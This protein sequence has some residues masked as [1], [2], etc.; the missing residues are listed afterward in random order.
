MIAKYLRNKTEFTKSKNSHS[1][2]ICC[3]CLLLSLFILGYGKD[4]YIKNDWNNF[5]E[6][7][8]LKDIVLCDI[9]EKFFVFL[10][11]LINSSTYLVKFEVLIILSLN[12]L[13]FFFLI[14]VSLFKDSVNLFNVHYHFYSQMTCDKNDLS[15]LIFSKIEISINHFIINFNFLSLC[16]FLFNLIDNISL[17]CR[18]LFK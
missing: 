14:L 3:R 5:R 9:S 16:Y 10:K 11:N 15:E 18:H 12:S 13:I 1:L 4:C 6:Q 7:I 2:K 8:S 17:F